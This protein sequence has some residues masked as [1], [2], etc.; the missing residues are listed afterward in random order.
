MAFPALTPSKRSFNPGDFPIKKFRAQSGEETRV[1]YG[2]KR[3]GMKMSLT[4]RNVTDAQA[5]EFLDHYHEMK[6][7]FTTFDIAAESKGGWTGNG[8]A[9]GASD[10]DN[11]YRYSGPPQITQIK[12][13]VSHVHVNLIGVL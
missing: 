2:S 5:E 6:G 12:E 10:W 13:G 11:A 1:L 3:T 4:Y 9:I 8:D 7:T